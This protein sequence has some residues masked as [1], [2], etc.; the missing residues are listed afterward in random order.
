M[1]NC[2]KLG[3]ITIFNWE[4][5]SITL[6]KARIEILVRATGGNSLARARS[7][8]QVDSYN[9]DKLL[10]CTKTDLTNEQQPRFIDLLKEFEALFN[11]NP[12]RTTLCEHAIDTGEASS[13]T[14]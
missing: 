14:R 4:D 13:V 8:W 11:D 7:V 5:G 1:N 12:G 10:H 9:E 6:G 3:E 2:K